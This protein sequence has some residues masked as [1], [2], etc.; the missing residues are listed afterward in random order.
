LFFFL[1]LQQIWLL[2]I[3]GGKASTKAQ[4]SKQ[5]NRPKITLLYILSYLASASVRPYDLEKIVLVVV[6][7]EHTTLA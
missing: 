4:A 7:Y 5:L 2:D 6:C 3:R 1:W